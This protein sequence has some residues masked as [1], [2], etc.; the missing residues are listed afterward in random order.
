MTIREA[1]TAILDKSPGETF[2]LWGPDRSRRPCG[3]VGV[4]CRTPSA[5]VQAVR[6]PGGRREFCVDP[7]HGQYRF[8]P[9]VQIG[10][11]IF[12]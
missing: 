1:V 9:G 6:R 11:A 5:S 10:G 2:S 12:D 8:V 7:V 3:R 4:S